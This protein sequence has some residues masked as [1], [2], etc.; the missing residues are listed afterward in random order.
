MKKALLFITLII[1]CMT[2]CTGNKNNKKYM[3]TGN[4]TLVSI[5]TTLGDITVKLYDETP[6]H[7]NNFIKIE[8]NG[9]LDSKIGRAHV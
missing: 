2:A 9:V 4:E 1:G 3:K 8:N 5:Q 6:K 7:R